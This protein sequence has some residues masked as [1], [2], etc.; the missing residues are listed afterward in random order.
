MNKMEKV[1]ATDLL[2]ALNDLGY[3]DKS[4]REMKDI[5]QGVLKPD[6]P[7]VE[8]REVKFDELTALVH[9]LIRWGEKLQGT[10]NN[11]EEQSC[12]DWKYEDWWR[13]EEETLSQIRDQVHRLDSYLNG[14]KRLINELE[15]RWH[16]EATL[17]RKSR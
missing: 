17:K 6:E 13:Q 16:C 14:I 2:K 11:R 8:K 5:I 3:G 12:I 10:I 9:H 15:D 7:E 4:L 1:K